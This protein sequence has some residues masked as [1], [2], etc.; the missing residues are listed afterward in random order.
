MVSSGILNRV[1]FVR[2][3][4]LEKLSAS[5][6]RVI[7]LVYFLSINFQKELFEK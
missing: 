2:T 4:D 3:D 7:T 1:A 5:I 6:I